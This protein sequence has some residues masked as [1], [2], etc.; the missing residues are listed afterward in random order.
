MTM[1]KRI[2]AVLERA[3]VAG[4]WDDEAVGRAMLAEMRK[5][6]EVMTYAAWEHLDGSYSHERIASAVKAMVDAELN[7]KTGDQL[8]S[9]WLRTVQRMPSVSDDPDT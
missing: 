8:S 4:G 5:P 2:T 1:L 6:T 3:R 9:E 7:E